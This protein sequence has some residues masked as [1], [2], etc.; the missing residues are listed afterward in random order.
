MRLKHFNE[1][2]WYRTVVK[3]WLGKGTM[4]GTARRE[5]WG[6]RGRDRETVSRVT[7]TRTWPQPPLAGQP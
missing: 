7:S 3:E 6:E 2:R 5:T 4:R 1:D